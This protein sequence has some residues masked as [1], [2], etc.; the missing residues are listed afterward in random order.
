MY[1]E[2]W[3]YTRSFIDSLSPQKDREGQHCCYTKKKKE[4]VLLKR[5]NKR[6]RKKGQ[7]KT[8]THACR[9]S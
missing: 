7:A 6:G 4:K 9:G 8:T 1:H 2:M 3:D 5:E